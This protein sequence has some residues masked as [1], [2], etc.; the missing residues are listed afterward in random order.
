MDLKEKNLLNYYKKVIE[1]NTFTET[2]IFGFLI[3]MRNYI[4]EKDLTYI[5]EFADLIA[6]RQRNQ[7]LIK[8]AIKN[9]IDNE[10]E[11][12]INNGEDTIMGYN[13]IINTE[14]DSEWKKLA[15]D[16]HIKISNKTLKEIT[17]CIYSLAQKT[18]YYEEDKKKKNKL[19]KQ[20]GKV[21]LI[22]DE[23][24]NAICL[25]TTEKNRHS[26]YICFAVYE[27]YKISKSYN[28]NDISSKSVSYT[29]RKNGVLKLITNK[30]EIVEEII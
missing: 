8:E 24:N 4:Y 7:G 9:A 22:A 18:K 14:W 25:A 30:K 23:I 13:G 19:G 17:L 28:I 3:L 6:H 20:L 27:G 5:K 26:L 12:T 10:Y 11:M 21:V 2:D 29:V 15:K 1:D 16:N